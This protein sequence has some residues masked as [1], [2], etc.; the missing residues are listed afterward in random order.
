MII[1]RRRCLSDTHLPTVRRIVL[2][3]RDVTGASP[4]F[5]VKDVVVSSSTHGNVTRTAAYTISFNR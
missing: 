2:R 4:D 1:G 5:G 3:G